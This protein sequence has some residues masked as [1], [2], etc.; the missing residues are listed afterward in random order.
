MGIE[1]AG[2]SPR[3]PEI[4]E[5]AGAETGAPAAIAPDLAAVIAAWPT[6][7]DPIRRALLALIGGAD[8]P[9][10]AREPRYPADRHG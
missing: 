9:A 4:P 10:A 7:P 6:L 5:Q 2:E 1:P 3:N 8:P